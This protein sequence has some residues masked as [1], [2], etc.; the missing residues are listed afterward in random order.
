MESKTME[1]LGFISM[2]FVG[3]IGVLSSIYYFAIG[4]TYN[5]VLAV[6]FIALIFILYS[7]EWKKR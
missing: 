5:G 4:N 6:F 7:I 3:I 1:I 2:V